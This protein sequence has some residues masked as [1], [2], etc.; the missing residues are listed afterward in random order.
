[1]RFFFYGT[2][3]AGSENRVARTVHAQLRDLGP[4]TASGALHAVATPE[5]WYPVLLPGVAPV[6][7]RLYETAPG[8]GEADLAA[9]DAWEDFDATDP[10]GSLYIR[11][12]LIV[13]DADEATHEAQG[14]RFNR[15]LPAGTRLIEDGDFRAWI[16]REGRRPYGAP[17]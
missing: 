17:G 4:A 16:A 1:M 7:G 5:G 2:L 13:A 6:H 8:F 10:A 11:A 3:I 12:T 9:L 15:P 14:Y